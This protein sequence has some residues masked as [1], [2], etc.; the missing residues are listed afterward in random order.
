[1]LSGGRG[2]GKVR[3]VSTG[4]LQNE[5]GGEAVLAL[6]QDGGLFY[7]VPSHREILSLVSAWDCV[8][9]VPDAR[10]YD[11]PSARHK[12]RLVVV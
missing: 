1:M 5:Q 2:T 4:T 3:Q 9:A 11:T 10:V 8:C 7:P 12:G 6:G